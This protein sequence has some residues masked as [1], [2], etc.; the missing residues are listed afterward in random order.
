L[1]ENADVLW[2]DNLYLTVLDEFGMWDKAAYYASDVLYM[3]YE[4]AYSDQHSAFAPIVNAG[5]ARRVAKLTGAYVDLQYDLTGSWVL[6]SSL[7]SYAV[8]APGS[9]LITGGTMATPTI[10]YDTAGRY[11]IA[12][13]ITAANGK[14]T[15]V[16]RTV[17]IWSDAAPLISGFVVSANP[18]GSY[19]Q[20]G[21][22][23]GVT[24]YG[25]EADISSIRDRTMVT[26]VAQDY[27]NGVETSIGPVTG[28]ENI[29]GLPAA[30]ARLIMMVK[31]VA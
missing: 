3:D 16:Y 18:R 2:D 26:L 29:A 22:E 11:R 23:F 10:R 31:N 12:F 30:A 19:S 20:G 21:W 9:A 25:D 7:S 15:T 28:F 24:V 27:Y 13:T 6:G 5:P 14:S 8:S 4:I 17:R 1:G